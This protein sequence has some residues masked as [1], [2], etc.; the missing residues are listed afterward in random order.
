VS[1]GAAATDPPRAHNPDNLKAGVQHACF[2]EPE[3]NP[4][5]RDLAAH[6]ATTVL[7]TRTAKA[8]DK[9]KVS[10]YTSCGGSTV[11]SAGRHRRS[12]FHVYLRGR[13]APGGV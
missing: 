2:Y 3:L 7:P 4:T 11:I 9:A 6:Y 12:P 13:S 10:Y 5:Y 8:R 1:Q